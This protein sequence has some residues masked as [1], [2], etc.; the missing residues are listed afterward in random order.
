MSLKVLHEAG[1][2]TRFHTV[3]S[4]HQTTVAHHSWGVCLILLRI[5]SPSSQLLA[6]AI[7]HDLAES[8]TG[9]VPATAK[10]L[11]SELTDSLGQLEF[12]FERE[13]NLIVDLSDDE[14][15]LLKW[16]DMFELIMYADSEI[17]LGNTLFKP[18][19]ERGIAYLS[20]RPAPNAVAARFLKDL[21]S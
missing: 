21:Q 7:Y 16:A 18:I 4:V 3:R 14:T 13:H 15:T 9:D 11:S 12:N 1:T 20:Q 6:A 8:V 19:R 5:T 2:V 10:W 17:A